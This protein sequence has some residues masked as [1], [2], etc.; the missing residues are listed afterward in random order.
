MDTR[1]ILVIG[2]S[3]QLA[4]AFAAIETPNAKV[5][6]LG[7]PDVDLTEPNTLEA[8]I[9]RVEPHVLINAAAYTSV[10]GAESEP[11]AAALLNVEGPRQL[12]LACERHGR[13]LIHISTDCVFD[14]RL[15]R[16]YRETDAC[17]PLGVYGR[18][19]LDG[20]NAVLE[21]HKQS[22]VVRV[23]WIFS[24]FAGNFVKK[25]LTLAHENCELRVVNDQLG[26]PTHAEDLANGLVTMGRA[27]AAP[28]FTDWG[29]YHLA[30]SGETNRA[31][32]ARAV[33]EDSARLGGPVASIAGVAT[34]DYPTPAQRPLNARLNSEKAAATFG[35]VL[36]H[37]RERLR[38]CVEELVRDGTRP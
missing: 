32:Q 35:I 22:L 13:P 11:E 25:M 1:R 29:I 5:I 17:N 19:K 21:T 23:S 33:F 3:G 27:I 31:S 12:A 9:D 20:E 10:D 18:T 4:H 38:S 24:R 6:C 8:A 14:G 37:W 30:G 15:D 36:P 2:R 26:C 16:P 34:V 28:S 7:R